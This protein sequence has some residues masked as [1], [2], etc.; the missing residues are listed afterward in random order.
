VVVVLSAPEVSTKIQITEATMLITM[1]HA[2]C[3][4]RRFLKRTPITIARPNPIGGTEM[5]MMYAR[6]R[7]RLAV[8]RPP[9]D[10]APFLD[11]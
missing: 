11:A 2:P 9:F 3:F 5:A 8:A 7:S 10:A 1:M 6:T 4:D